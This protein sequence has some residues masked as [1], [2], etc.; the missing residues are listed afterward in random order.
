[1]DRFVAED[2]QQQRTGA[3][4]S[5]N[6]AAIAA[7]AP[8]QLDPLREFTSM[9][10]AISSS[11]NEAAVPAAMEV[12]RS[13]LATG[14]ELLTALGEELE[15]FFGRSEAAK[16]SLPVPGPTAMNRADMLIAIDDDETA[17]KKGLP[18]FVCATDS[19]GQVLDVVLSVYVRRGRLP[20]PG[21]VLFATSLTSM[22]EIEL[23]FRRWLAASAYGRSG[24]VFCLA[25]LHVLSYTQQCGLVDRLRS[26]LSGGVSEAA[27]LLLVSGRP[28]QVVLNQLSRHSVDLPPLQSS[29]L[30]SAC[31]VAF[32]T[33]VGATE[34]VSSCI[35]GGGKSHRIMREV[36]ER[37]AAGE[38][39]LYARV[40]VRESTTPA[41]LVALLAAS[42][43]RCRSADA[44][45][46]LAVHVDIGHIIPAA[47]NTML[48]VTLLPLLLL[49]FHQ[50]FCLFS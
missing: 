10:Y 1:M 44:S 18:L 32:A 19:V 23:L 21:E 36:A 49:S 6:A 41:A 43:E 22:E 35:N 2:M 17:G 12:L 38:Q 13:R 46:S 42:S 30:K 8:V 31:A 3:S 28:Q 14:D 27:T 20:E 39:V 29:E 11:V 33:H 48:F 37:Q 45:A 34:A 50:I 24:M 25:D 47:C 9:L 16:R 5:S 15:S 26:L 7:P 40:P 4:A